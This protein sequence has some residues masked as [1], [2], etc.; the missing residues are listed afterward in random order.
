MCS[1][2]KTPKIATLQHRAT[3]Y[4]GEWVIYAAENLEYVARHEVLEPRG[5]RK[6]VESIA[7]RSLAEAQTFTGYLGAYGW[8]K[9]W[10]L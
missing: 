8:V 1:A 5:E 2:Y 7:L 10:D 3:P 4:R 9:V 6:I